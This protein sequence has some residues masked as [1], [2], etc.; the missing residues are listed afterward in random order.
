MKKHTC[1]LLFLLIL[2]LNVGCIYS[3]WL[4]KQ[5][6][7]KNTESA[8]VSISNLQ[9]NLNYSLE[10]KL[11]T[12]QIERSFVNRNL[13]TFTINDSERSLSFYLQERGSLIM[14]IPL[15]ACEDCYDSIFFYIS[16]HK[17]KDKVLVLIP[18]DD[19]REMQ[20]FF[21]RNSINLKLIALKEN[22]NEFD[23]ENEIAPYFFY[24]DSNDI[25]SHFY[26][27]Q[28]SHLRDT[29]LYLDI[30]LNKYLF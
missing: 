30:I 28:K 7:F 5:L 16:E 21:K 15:N 8:N 13:Q 22:H 2:I 19:Y 18:Y 11:K 4:E 24:I 12:L 27:P 10:T 20:L 3:L 9:M 29:L 17:L 14:R 26:I 1:L 6:N 23:F 25:A